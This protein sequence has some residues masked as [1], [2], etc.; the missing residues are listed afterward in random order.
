MLYDWET[1]AV[2]NA[3][4]GAT[5]VHLHRWRSFAPH[6]VQTLR[7]TYLTLT[8]DPENDQQCCTL[9]IMW[10]VC[11]SSVWMRAVSRER[12]KVLTSGAR[13]AGAKVKNLFT[14]LAW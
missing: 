10:Q 3:F 11:R 12:E 2:S 7:A 9:A 1:I 6:V 5:W 14:I 13:T 4:V 8:S